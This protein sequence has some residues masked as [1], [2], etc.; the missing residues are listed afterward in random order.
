MNPSRITKCV[1]WQKRASKGTGNPLNVFHRA[2]LHSLGRHRQLAA[3]FRLK[4]MRASLELIL[5]GGN[6]VLEVDVEL[7]KLSSLHMGL[8]S[9]KDNCRQ[10]GA[11]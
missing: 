8:N 9:K 5:Y 1:D 10:P 7:P 4:F 6:V 2:W 11:D 3:S